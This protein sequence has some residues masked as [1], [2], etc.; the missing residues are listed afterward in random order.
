MAFHKL[1]WCRPK[2]I[3]CDVA[4]EELAENIIFLFFQRIDKPDYLK[5][6]S[7]HRM[8]S[9]QHVTKIGQPKSDP[10]LKYSELEKYRI[11]QKLKV[12][13]IIQMFMSWMHFTLKQNLSGISVA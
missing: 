9:I 12:H 10:C 8:S 6:A 7:L 1:C 13:V 2:L 4:V 3:I 5:N 11:L